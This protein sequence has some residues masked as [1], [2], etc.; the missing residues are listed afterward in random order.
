MN[1]CKARSKK[2]LAKRS[3]NLASITY[4]YPQLLIRYAMMMLVNR[5]YL[6]FNELISQ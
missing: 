4:T 2:L 3:K 1:E 6:Y 5:D